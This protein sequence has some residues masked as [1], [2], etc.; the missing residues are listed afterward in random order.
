MTESELKIT[1]ATPFACFLPILVIA[2]ISIFAWLFVLLGIADS[3]TMG[4]RLKSIAVA[5][6]QLSKGR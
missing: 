3:R 2:P 6:V 4:L 1:W 5:I